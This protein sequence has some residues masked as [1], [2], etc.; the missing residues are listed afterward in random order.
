[1][2]GVETRDRSTYALEIA[3]TW[4]GVPV[5]SDE[6]ARIETTWTASD[7]EIAIDAPYHGDPPPAGAAG[8]TDGLW[9]YEV[10][11][12]F[13][14]GSEMRYVELEFGPHGH[15]LGLRLAG[16]R[17][18]VGDVRTVTYRTERPGA[19][20]TGRARVAS[21]DLPDP[22]VQWNAFAIHGRGAARRYLAAAPVPGDSPDFH[23][24]DA[25]PEFPG[26]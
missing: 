26:R 25:F 15:W 5:G 18:R 9:E 16:V 4:D 1:M 2:S 11:E 24:I 13:L 3:H 12:L 7:L 23:R 10:V 19:R 14:V 6:R 8:R 22:I 20:W 17:H 21:A